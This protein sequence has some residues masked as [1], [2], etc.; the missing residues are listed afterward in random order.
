MSFE[1]KPVKKVLC[2]EC[3]TTETMRVTV[4]S[5]P[6]GLMVPAHRGNCKSDK[7]EF[8]CQSVDS[9]GYSYYGSSRCGRPVKGRFKGGYSYTAGVPGCGLHLSV[10]RRMLEKWEAER[11]AREVASYLEDQLDEKIKKVK[12]ETGLRCEKIYRHGYGAQ[13]YARYL[14][15]TDVSI[16][17]DQLILAIEIEVEVEE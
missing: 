17:I 1:H 10:E 3:G 7:I 6:A 2:E 14:D 15:A 13:Q 11:S 9:G 16:N 4:K 12:D 5:I 8:C